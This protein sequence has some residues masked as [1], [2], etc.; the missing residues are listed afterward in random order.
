MP[1]KLQVWFAYSDRADAPLVEEFDTKAEGITRAGEVLA[2]DGVT[3]NDNGTYHYYPISALTH[4]K[5]SEYEIPE[6]EE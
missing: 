6:E 4:I 3:V 1:W 2:E 5:L